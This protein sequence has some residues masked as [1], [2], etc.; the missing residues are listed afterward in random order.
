MDEVK[1]F[2]ID[3]MSIFFEAMPFII[4]GAI[5]AGILEELLPQ[6]LISRLVPKNKFLA[7][8][9]VIPSALL[10]LIFPMCECGIVPVMRR[11][12]RKGL[13]LSCSIAYMLA[14][15]IINIVVIMSTV[16]AFAPHGK[17]GH[18]IIGLRIGL[19]FLVAVGTALIVQRLHSKYGNSLLTDLTRPQQG[20]ESPRSLTVIS[21]PGDDEAESSPRTWKQRLAN[22]TETAL[23]DFVDI[24]VFLTL[25]AVLSAISRQFLTEKNINEL[26][27]G[28]PV[29]S[30]LVMMG[31]AVL[32]CLCSEADAFVAA[33][34]K[35]MHPAAK[36]SFLVLGPMLDLKLIMLFTRVF[37]SKLIWTLI[38]SLI[39][40]VLVYTTIVYFVWQ[41]RA[42]PVSAV[43]VG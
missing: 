2:I 29:L 25:G 43:P 17:P 4:L 33:S 23:H 7:T 26:T 24:S 16:V 8:L 5:L 3:F 21:Q 22:I 20:G 34:Y 1:N 40:Q 39:L 15:P 6:T 18:Y 27:T 13:P 37:R 12:L 11:L 31:A 35:T 30:I 41:S 9:F 10:G 19:G 14:G 38:I 36:L 42:L 28:Y 32:M